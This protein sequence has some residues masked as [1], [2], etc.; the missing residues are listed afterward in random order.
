MYN[1]SMT[2]QMK[3]I[4]RPYDA[5]KE[6]ALISQGKNRLLARI[7]A[8]RKVDIDSIDIFISSEYKDISNPYSLYGIKDAAQLFV[9]TIKSNGNISTIGDFDADGI[10]SSVMIKELCNVFNVNCYSFL[11]SRLEHGYGL[12]EKS[13]KAFIDRQKNK[14]DLLI[15]LDCGINSKKEIEELKKYANKIMIIDHHIIDKD[16][17]SSNA[18][19][20]VSWHLGSTCEMCTCGEVYQFI[21]AIH[22]LNKNI[23]PIEFLTF[24]SIGTIADCSPIVGDNRIIVKNG[25]T[26]YAINHVR[27]SGLLALMKQA[28][29]D[30]PSLTESDVAFKIGPRINAVGRLG[31]ADIVFSLLTE[32][33]TEIATKIAEHVVG[34]NDE[35]KKIQKDIENEAVSCV[36]FDKSKFTH[37]IFLKSKNWHVGV[38]GIVAS[39]IT[40]EFNKP[41]IV[42]G[43]SN[44]LGTWKGSGRTCNGINLKEVLD[45]CPEIFSSYGGHAGAVGVTL[46]EDCLNK[47]AEVFNEACKK[48]CEKNN[49]NT[50]SYKYYDAKLSAKLITETTADMIHDN[51]Y[52]YCEENNSEPVFLLPDV[53][54]VD[55][56]IKDGGTWR[57]LSFYVQKDIKVEYPFKMF[58]PKFNAEEID[59]KKADIYFQFPQKQ[60]IQGKFYKFELMCV[61]IVLK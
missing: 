2:E 26:S 13:V 3:W 37:G 50:E 33:D 46:K 1:N 21:R 49:I 58:S 60:E 39:R 44:E 5:N 48:Y 23:N 43:F 47:A 27:S 53:T 52:P 24:S 7:F 29:I 16:R 22:M 9:D 19:V 54:I 45:T 34:F 30:V 41:A 35:R 11:P 51:L 42:V 17:Y 20:V 15:I 18:D 31:E 4:K 61:D 38:V 8:Q 59:G 57:L 12:N 28:K 55:P 32:R 6:A 40:E 25:L 10:V 56:S 14:I 36:D